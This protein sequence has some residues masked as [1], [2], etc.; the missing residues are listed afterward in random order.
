[1]RCRDG[2]FVVAV[3]GGLRRAVSVLLALAVMAV[4]VLLITD[5]TR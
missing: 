5:T 3:R 4:V 2:G 1:M